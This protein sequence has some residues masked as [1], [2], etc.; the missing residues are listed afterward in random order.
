MPPP[1]DIAIVGAGV[2]GLFAAATLTRAG[3]TC[4]LV[5]KRALGSRQSIAAQGIIHGGLKYALTES[6]ANASRAIAHMPDTW[7]SFTAASNQ[8]PGA[9]DLSAAATLSEHTYL[10]TT[11][12]LASKLTTMTAAKLFRTPITRVDPADACPA[13]ARASNVNIYKVDEPVLDPHSLLASLAA[14][15]NCPITH[16]DES[17]LDTFDAPPG[18]IVYT[19]GSHNATLNPSCAQLRPLHMVFARTPTADSGD[20]LPPIYAHCVTTATKPR[21]TITSQIDEQCRPVWYIGGHPAETGND[22]PPLEQ[23]RR[24][25]AD[26]EEHLPWLS[27]DGLEWATLRVDRAEPLTAEGKRPDEPAVQRLD[28]PGSPLRLIAYPTKLALAPRLADLLLETLQSHGVTPTG[29]TFN[30]THLPPPPPVAQLPWNDPDLEW[31]AL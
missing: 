14:Q 25:K 1:P 27:F 28:K 17:I 29:K 4:L 12:S 30:P 9:I 31:H 16:A 7:R 11:R 18:V 19:A 24:A 13:L 26:L 15:T 22:V 5:E 20:R 23:I 10:F 8:Q 3:Y 6:A 21:L 2:A